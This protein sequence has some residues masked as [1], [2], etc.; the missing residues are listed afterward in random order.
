VLL[1]AEPRDIVGGHLLGYGYDFAHG[2]M[3]EAQRDT[4]RSLIARAT[5]GRLWMGARLPRHFRNWNWIAVGLQQPLLS[6]SI[7][8]EE[9]YDPR[10]FSL[11]LQ[12]AGDYLAHG[13]DASGMS[14][15]AV[16]YT[17]FGF[18][19]SDP[20]CVAATRRGENLLGHPHLR[21]M[22][23][24][25][26]HCLEPAGSHWTSHGDGG[27]RGP[28][29]WTVSLW[30]YFFPAD[31]RTQVLWRAYVR[32]AGRE[33]FSS[34]AH[35]IEPLL[36]AAADPDLEKGAKPGPWDGLPEAMPTT[37]FS[38]QCSSLIARSAW[39]PDAS[40]VQ[41]ECRT[42]S[43]G[44]S[45]E[46]A[47]RG[48][49]TFAAL[50]R[51]WAKENF[52]S[53]ETRHHNGILIDGRGQGYWPGPGRWLGWQEKGELVLASCDSTENYSWF[54]PKQIVTEPPREFSRF[55]YPRWSGYAAEASRFQRRYAGQRGERDTRPGVV[56]FWKGFEEG[57][58]RLW[59]EDAWPLRLPYNP[60]KHS[61]R[62]IAFRKGAHP[63]LLV[64]DDIRKDE[65]EH[66]YEWLMQTGPDTEL[67]S[68]KD[69]EVVL[70]DTATR[71]D[72]NGLP[73]PAKG[74]RQLLVRVLD[75]AD[76]ANEGDCATRP[77]IRLETFERKDTLE[78]ESGESGA[79]VSRSFGMDKRLVIPSRARSPRFKILLFP[80]RQGEPLPV[81]QW[82]ED[83]SVLTL[84]HAGRTDRYEFRAEPSGRTLINLREPNSNTP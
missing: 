56:A 24:W 65:G 84:S 27:D 67:A 51:T 7:E 36:W 29:L 15:E 60:V 19:W 64:V 49:F 40:L 20:F 55:T 58:P 44:A 4:V 69:R 16:G 72:E 28:G 38:A 43:V 34:K 8:G 22:P 46:H 80:F 74:A 73:V 79:P 75:M 35:I 57:G 41:F 37:W 26:L 25:Y 30:R 33:A 39:N 13:V 54:W 5:R 31:P 17:A 9:G 47:D 12:I 78:P 2:F 77:S 68:L 70:C 14:T 11:G 81:T 21:A 76:P 83:H 63:Y 1:D 61:F 62:S 45:H 18:V 3:T 52:R 59:D 66:L 23:D 6:L 71:R 10:V 50:G 82:N 53:V 42:D 32:E 48:N